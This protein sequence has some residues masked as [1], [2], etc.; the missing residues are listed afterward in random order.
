MCVTKWDN[1]PF[2]FENTNAGTF[3]NFVANLET[4]EKYKPS[5]L[6]KKRIF[7]SFYK[8][9]SFQNIKLIS[10]KKERKKVIFGNKFLCN[11]VSET[12]AILGTLTRYT[13]TIETFTNYQMH[14]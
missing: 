12:L 1:D 4:Y 7:R 13:E 2:S 3:L 8:E 6:N 11:K 10:K 14:A 9:R 5:V